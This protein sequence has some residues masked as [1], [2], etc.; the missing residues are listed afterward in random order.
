[1][2]HST[3]FARSPVGV[4]SSLLQ[5]RR[6]RRRAHHRELKLKL[7][8]LQ[9]DYADLHTALLEGALVHRHLCA[10]RLVRH[11]DIEIASEI[12]AVRYLPGDF[13]TVEETSG[14]VILAIGDVC[15]KGVAA[16]M[17]TPCLVGL[18]RAHAAASSELQAI[19]TGV[20]H[21]FCRMLAP[22][23]SLFIAR[24]DP[25]TG[26]L[27]YCRAGHPPAMLLRADGQLE[28]LS[29][30]GMLLGMTPDASFI[31]GCVELRPGDVLLAYSDGVLESRN[32]ADQEFGYERLEA[33]LRLAQ[34]GSAEAVLF[35]VLAAVQDFAAPHALIDDTSLVV[36][37]YRSDPH[38]VTDR[39]V[40]EA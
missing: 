34:V 9:K 22:L 32:N 11:G 1:V 10:P 40:A 7:A 19:V 24:L 28:S 29:E 3:F 12:F 6:S 13:F 36:V 31:T 39:T 25:A 23:T 16:G 15:G 27:D 5:A 35:S 30:G 4:Q 18:L 14:G 37:R 38:S 17:W 21:E 26:R 2:R 8:T 33:Q 20:N